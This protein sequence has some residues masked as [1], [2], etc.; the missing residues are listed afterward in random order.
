MAVSGSSSASYGALPITLIRANLPGRIDRSVFGT[1]ARPRSV[2]VAMSRRLSTKSIAPSRE[3]FVSPDSMIC[4]GFGV[5]R[6]L[7]R[8]P[9]CQSRLP[10]IDGLAM[11]L[12]GS[13]S[14]AS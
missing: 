5:S 3:G 9:S 4:T 10:R 7:G 11:P 8:R 2:P 13:E 6:E 1:T 14:D 12:E